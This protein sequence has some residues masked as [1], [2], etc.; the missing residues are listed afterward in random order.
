MTN[1]IAIG[2]HLSSVMHVTQPD[3]AIPTVIRTFLDE[4]A[5]YTHQQKEEACISH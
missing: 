2:T 3:T 1:L 4:Q 5:D